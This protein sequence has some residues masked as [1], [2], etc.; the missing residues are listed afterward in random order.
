MK[1]ETLCELVFHVQEMQRT[2]FFHSSTEVFVC[3]FLNYCS[4][5]LVQFGHARVFINVSLSWPLYR[6]QKKGRLCLCLFC[7]GMDGENE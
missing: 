3:C 5:C 6:R 1:K 4:E 7:R 2:L